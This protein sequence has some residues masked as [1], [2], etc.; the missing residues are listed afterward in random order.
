MFLDISTSILLE[1]AVLQVLPLTLKPLQPGPP[2]TRSHFDH[3]NSFH[4]KSLV[5]REGQNLPRSPRTTILSFRPLTGPCSP[6][7]QSIFAKSRQSKS[8]HPPPPWLPG[9]G[10]GEDGGVGGRGSGRNHSFPL[11]TH[12][13]ALGSTPKHSAY[14]NNWQPSR[15]F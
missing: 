14:N 1:L 9:W 11:H 2:Y 6:S 15:A 7:A 3:N 12:L 4:T 5:T 10:M 8:V 13:S